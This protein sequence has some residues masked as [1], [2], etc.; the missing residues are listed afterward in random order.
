LLPICDTTVGIKLS[1][2][3]KSVVLQPQ[4]KAIPFTYQNGTL[5][6]TVEKFTCH[7]II[8]IK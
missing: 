4:G 1:K 5:C 8:E 3:P 7:Q 6:Y 2:T